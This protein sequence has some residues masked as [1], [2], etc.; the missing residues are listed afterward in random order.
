MKTIRSIFQGLTL[1]AL[2]GSTVFAAAGCDVRNAEW[3][4]YLDKTSALPVGLQGSVA[5]VDHPTNRVLMLPV[6]GDLTLAPTA[7]PID[8]GFANTRST[9]DGK[10]FFVLTRGDVPRK[11]STDQGPSLQVIDGGSSPKALDKYELTDPLSGLEIDPQAEFAVVFPSASDS[12]TF[13]QN[14]NELIL[15]KLQQ[16]PSASNPVPISLRSFGGRPQAFNF[17][18]ELEVPGG[19]RRLLVTS[20]DRD[21]ALVDLSAP[22]KPE[23]TV[24]LTG[25]ADVLRPVGTAVTDGE[26]GVDTDARIA[27]RMANDNNVIV[28]D[29]LPKPAN[30]DSPHSFL[31]VPNINDVGGVPTDM[32]FV[33]TD[34]GLRLAA[35]VPSKKSLTLLEP[36]TGTT[37]DV[38]LGASF[39]RMTI[40][41]DIVGQTT[42]GGDIALVWSTSSSNVAFVALGVTIGKPYK[43]V[44]RVEL[45]E[46]VASVLDVP[47]PNA[48]LKIL[49]LPS[50][51]NF[52]VLDLLTRTASPILAGAGGAR[53]NVSRNGERAWLVAQ[54]QFANSIGQLNLTTLHPKN[55]YL[56]YG[57]SDA[58]E[59][60]RRD[61]GRA[62]VAIHGAGTM[63]ATVFDAQNPALDRS[64]EYLGL[65]LGEFQ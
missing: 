42:N 27:V 40:V 56:N 64:T 33:N 11:K 25:G 51:K 19:K 39:E 14:P 63:G 22:D 52:I 2:A 57:V 45:T 15:V 3:S 24:K 55:V 6:E 20:T 32:A 50:R 65:L 18:P 36:V 48:H 5:I 16:P 49:V 54:D 53:A 23:I 29:L 46:P 8:H 21:I 44:E 30:S 35:L 41:T 13:V 7:I 60:E 34:G 4:A 58:F 12:E 47:E 28:M 61:G 37:T 10:R 17:T 31:P 26:P 62:L 38:D 43:S 9:K 59:V 1:A